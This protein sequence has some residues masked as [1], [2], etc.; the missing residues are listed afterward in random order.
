MNETDV[1][2]R[3]VDALEA[4][5]VGPFVPDTHAQGG[6]EILPLAPSRWYLT[7]FLAPEG[8]RVPDPEDRDSTDGSLAAG[9][10]SSAEDA[11]AE[12]PEPKRPVRFPASMGL[13]VFLPPGVGDTI[14]VDVWYADYD[15]VE[16]AIDRDDKKKTGWK[17]VPYGPVPVTVPLDAS[18]LQHKDGIPVPGSRNLVLKGELRTTTMDGLDPGTRVL[19]LFLVNHRTAVERDRDT[20]FA[21]Q[22][23]M[24]LTY[25]RGFVSRP[26][27]RGEDGSDEDQRVLALAFRDQREWAVGHNTSVERPKVKNGKLTRLRTTQLPCFEVPNVVHRPIADATLGMA[28]LAKL[29]AKGLA[30][31]LSPLLEAYEAWVDKQ[32]YAPL[33]RTTLEGTRDDLMSK[34]DGA[35][36]RI[37]EGIALLG[38]KPEVLRAF[39]LANQA[40]HVAALQADQTREDPRYVG[41][42]QPE[43]RPFQLAF[44]LLNLPSLASASHPD[45]K[46]AELIYF[47]TGGGKTEAYLGLIAFTLL[48]RRIRGQGTPHEGRGV[49]VL[50]RYTLRL[51]TLDQLGRAATLMC[52]LEELRRRN[53]KELGNARFT[54]GLWVG[55]SASANRLRDVHQ[56]LSDYTPGRTDSPF[57]LTTCPWCGESIKI[58][59]IKL[60]DAEGKPTKKNFARAAVYCDNAKCLYTE[61]KVP[62]LGLPVVFVDE[63]IYQEVPCFLVATVDKF[64]MMP[65]RGDAG[66]LFGRATHV[67]DQRAYGVMHEFKLGARPLPEGFLPPELIVQDELHLI[68]GPLGTMVGLYEAAVDYLCERPA[69]GAPRPPKVICS[70]ATVRRARDQIQALFGRTMSLFPPRGI[71]DGDNFFSQ[72][73]HDK[74]GRLYVGVGAPGRALRAVSVR[75]YAV[76]LA[77]AQKH[78]DRK[79]DPKQPADPYMTLIGYFNSLR[80]LGGM[81]RLVEDEVRNRIDDIEAEKRPLNFIG[82]HPWAADRKLEMPAELTSREPTERV[83]ETKRRLAARR[84][85][86]D[87]EPLDVVLAS[88]MISV[89]LDVDRL[90]LMVVT[91]QPKTTSEYIQA[92]SRV[93]RAYP[94]LVV[95]CLNVMRPRDR[96]HYE[97]F[98][99]YHE[100]FYREVEATSVTPFSGQALDR[101]LVGSLLS[102]IRHGIAPMEPPTGVMNIHEQR[103]AAEE[104]LGWMVGRARGHRKFPD[105]D[106]ETRI[107]NLVRARGRSFLDAWERVVD[108]ARTG[109]ASR[110]Y[111]KNDRAGSEGLHLLFTAS[112][113][114]PADHDARCFQVPTS[115]RDVEPS[116]PVWLRFKQL[117]ER[118]G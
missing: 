47:P 12:E 34:A 19:S 36:K 81:R 32:R 69:Y 55:A 116:V 44:V 70:T 86:T 37:A 71:V 49:A 10:E 24:Q 101:G 52:A 3:L 38:Q 48:L 98:V 50:L 107:A 18:V 75:S 77:A 95:T 74:P 108:K 97:R 15:K 92:T 56:A 27:R 84:T 102:M 104:L 62:G 65:W 91:G 54:I 33:D 4:D 51:L 114:P 58:Q 41:G 57:P 111:S 89:G 100:S 90:G 83:K 99:A 6:Q 25:E 66:M 103:P 80:E 21:F 72:I 64:A 23:R 96:S 16:V 35:R 115:M 76:L 59:N 43:W 46:L 78:F 87:P 40:M 2:K 88:N 63:Q 20:Q 60:V 112:D 113:D 9:S 7:G 14:Q 82:P 105:D 109:A 8:G 117:D 106:A 93:G 17:R 110:V 53:P 39:K 79:G 67:D 30:N 61:A 13:S 5:L 26:N 1:R 68:S 118:G 94:G 29:D 45:R 73:E 85:S 22:V 11:G 31:A 28:D 42:K